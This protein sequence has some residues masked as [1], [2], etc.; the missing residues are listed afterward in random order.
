MEEDNFLTMK[1]LVKSIEETTY[2]ALDRFGEI[3]P[4]ND[5]LYKC[6]VT[7]N[8]Q[9]KPVELSSLYGNLF[10]VHK[11]VIYTY[12]GNG[13]LKS[14]D[15]KSDGYL[16]R[17]SVYQFDRSGKHTAT[18]VYGSNGS[19]SWKHII[20]YNTDGKCQEVKYYDGSGGSHYVPTTY[21]HE[22]GNVIEMQR[23][24][25][26]EKTVYD[27]SGNITRSESDYISSDGPD[28]YTYEYDQKGN[29][30]KQIKYEQPE[31]G[32]ISLPV[33]ITIREITYW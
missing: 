32:G 27:S 31:A 2:N 20:T 33:Q 18:S 30:V 3:V 28:T 11:E 24:P 5:T 25:G 22:N 6:Q 1:G 21:R 9:G 8:G 23:W 26:K 7:F 29:W 14:I 19:L 12:D 15:D 4:G 17:K 13:M 10:G 16:I